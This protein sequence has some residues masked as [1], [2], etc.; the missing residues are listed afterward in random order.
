MSKVVFDGERQLIIVNPGE[1]FIEA[2]RDLYSAWK[3]WVL[4]ED[5]SKYK[6]AF[7]IV[8]GNSLP[9]GQLG[10]TYFLLDGWKIRPYEGDH[11]LTIKGNIYRHDGSD[12]IEDTIG[13]FKVTVSMT[14]SNL[15]DIVNSSGSSVGG[16]VDVQLDPEVLDGLS[17]Q[18]EWTITAS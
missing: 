10:L 4:E 15:I 9:T 6:M 5:N 11:R 7:K 17:S 18:E 16:E 14:V 8:G 1:N 2:R 3:E 13:D 12:P